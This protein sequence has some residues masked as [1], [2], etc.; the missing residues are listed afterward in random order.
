MAG[1]QVRCLCCPAAVRGARPKQ[2]LGKINCA[3]SANWTHRPFFDRSVA[4]GKP[5][6]PEPRGEPSQKIRHGGCVLLAKDERDGCNIRAFLRDGWSRSIPQGN[7]RYFFG[8]LRDCCGK[9]NLA[10]PSGEGGARSATDEVIGCNGSCRS[11][12]EEPHPPLTRSPLPRE[13]GK[14]NGISETKL[15]IPAAKDEGTA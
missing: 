11:Y 12:V 9:G 3:D 8:Y 15:H 2:E 5:G 13:E 1:K 10:F 7:G 6:R 14:K 4:T